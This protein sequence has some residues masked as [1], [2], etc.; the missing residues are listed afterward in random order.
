ML[1]G[2]EEVG[3]ELEVEH[4]INGFQVFGDSY[5]LQEKLNHY[6]ITLL[7]KKIGKMTFILN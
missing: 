2:K 4:G 1:I 5:L 3:R 6:S 7:S